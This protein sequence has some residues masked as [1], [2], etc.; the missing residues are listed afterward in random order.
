MKR[1]YT[2]L[3]GRGGLPIIALMVTVSI[4]ALIVTGLCD[5]FLAYQKAYSRQSGASSALM[6]TDSA[7]SDLGSY[8]SD[9]MKVAVFNRFAAG[10]VLAVCL[11]ADSAYGIYIPTYGSGPGNPIGY[12][13]GQTVVFY[14][15][16]STGAYSRSGSIL[17]A[18][19]QNK[20]EPPSD[21]RVTPD[22]TWSLYPGTTIGRIAP[23]TSIS[24]TK[25]DLAQY[26][27][28]SITV[29]SSYKAGAGNI[30]LTRTR[31]VCLRSQLY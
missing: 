11:P 3:R 19:T 28:V 8:V 16:D 1:S 22:S 24:F 7:L 29:A 27:Y 14:L 31:N 13:S 4:L 17:W 18:G 20:W 21:P 2:S 25:P 12:Q 10:D 30:T 6:A 15:S 9:A 5:V 26:A 23:V